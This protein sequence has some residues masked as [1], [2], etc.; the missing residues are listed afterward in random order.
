MAGTSNRGGGGTLGRSKLMVLAGSRYTP[1]TA[2]AA[3]TALTIRKPITIGSRA[4][5]PVIARSGNGLV[6]GPT[7]SWPTARK[8]PQASRMHAPRGVRPGHGPALYGCDVR[9]PALLHEQR[10]RVADIERG[11]DRHVFAKADAHQLTS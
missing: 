11:G 1:H 8:A 2:L 10:D 5:A 4:V 3:P 6:G 7:S 9:V